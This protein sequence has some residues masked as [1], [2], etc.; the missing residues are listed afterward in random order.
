MTRRTK[1]TPHFELSLEIREDTFLRPPRESQ[2]NWLLNR[3]VKETSD[4][5][6]HLDEIAK[7]FVPGRDNVAGLS[8]RTSGDLGDHE[9]MEDWQIP[10]MEAMASIVTG[11]HGD[12][13]EV[14]FGRGIGSDFIQAKGVASHT[15]IECN[16]S[17][18]TRFE[19]WQAR[20]SPA[21]EIRL[22]PGRWQDVIDSLSQFDGIFFHTYP[23]NES[24]FV[25]YVAQSS[26]FAEHF[27][28]VAAC[29]LRP[30]GVF[31][32]LTNETDSLSRAHQRALF[33][34]FRSISLSRVEDLD[35]PTDTADSMWSNSMVIVRAEK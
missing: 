2:R 34:H 6:E 10:I 14:G 31:T 9:I 13:L 32:Y 35:V 8:D 22:V 30:N 17:V 33:A 12:V 27:F 15:I 3:L 20:Q 29:H 16:P 4:E 19:S 5:L 1:R 26:T 23:L 21:T 24:E 11:A 25:Q 18:I 7:T 28:C